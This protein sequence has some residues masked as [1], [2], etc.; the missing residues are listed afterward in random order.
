MSGESNGIPIAC[1][2]SG[3]EQDRRQGV[4]GE[5][6]GQARR[7]EELEDGYAFDFAWDAKLAVELTE[8]II[9]ERACCPFFTFELV[10]ERNAGPVRL[11]VK[12][13]EGVKEFIGDQLIEAARS[14]R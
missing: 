13:P 7:V 5:I 10:F 2:L 1:N 14:A 4:A 9:F 12:G 8:F 6:L 3:P 11:R